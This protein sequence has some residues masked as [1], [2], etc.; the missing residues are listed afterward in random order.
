ME[1]LARRKELDSLSR[2]YDALDSNFVPIYGRRR[3][4]KSAL[5]LEFIKDKSSIYFLGKQAPALLQ[6]K[7]LLEQAATHFQEP[8]LSE[9]TPKSWRHVFELIS[10]RIESGDGKCV[11]ALDEF[12]WMVD[13]SPELP[14]VIQELWDTR[15]LAS[16]KVFLILCGSYIG[17]MEREVLG[18]KSP[19]FGRR[20]G[21]IHLKPFPFWE[22]AEFHPDESPV[23][24]AA[25]FF[26]CG[27]VPQY[28]KR[29]SS[30]LSVEE[31]IRREILDEF[32]PL[33]R[34]PDFLLRE[35]LRELPKYYA[36]LTQLAHGSKS[37]TEM[38][39]AA[40]I[41]ERSAPY[42]LN[43]LLEL[44]YI[45]KR[46]PLN[47]NPP[48]R[49]VRFQLHDPLLR[50]WFRFVYPHQS[51]IRQLEPRDA[52]QQLVK[53]GLSQY[54][55]SCFERLCQDWLSR[56]YAES[57]VPGFQVGEYWDTTVQID[58]V[59]WRED[60]R[61]DIGECKWGAVEA[62]ERLAKELE[63]KC[64]LYPDTR[65]ATLGKL[66]FVKSWK[67]KSLPGVEVTT[68]QDIYG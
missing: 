53:P 48:S 63:R 32:S 28:L 19:L 68:L 9:V 11:L 24:K 27:G 15:W 44:G 30:R 7:E 13:A 33:S 39:R 51:L 5:I 10:D 18:H 37:A 12:Q 62:P 47:D 38:A 31:N 41:P 46:L 56:K 42:Y 60:Q 14:S 34:E 58:V 49:K 1:F 3:V 16:G 61:T 6:Q 67:G 26:I 22:A 45:R 2:E 55:G 59:G 35:E 29:F 64:Q 36:I 54:F 43:Q 8:L 21:Q 23:N 4:G 57:G 66:L 52:F 50:F 65:G 40:G 25:I 17:F 20:S